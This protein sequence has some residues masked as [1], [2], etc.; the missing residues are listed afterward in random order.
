MEAP[1][2]V[3]DRALESWHRHDAQKNKCCDYTYESCEITLLQLTIVEREHVEIS[4]VALVNRT[5]I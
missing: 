1:A 5:C 3:Y 2:E 4:F